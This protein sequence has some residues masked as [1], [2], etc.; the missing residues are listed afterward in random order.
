MKKYFA[1]LLITSI[2]ILTLI[3]GCQNSGQDPNQQPSEIANT[4]IVEQPSTPTP[5]P[6]ET[7]QPKNLYLVSNQ[8]TDGNLFSEVSVYL[9]QYSGQNRFIFSNVDSLNGLVTSDTDLIVW[10]ESDQTQFQAGQITNNPQ[11]IIFT[12]EIKPDFEQFVQIKLQNAQEIF[13]AGYIS[14]MIAND[15]RTGGILPNITENNTRYAEIFENGAHYLCGRC[16]P[17]YSP[18]VSFPQTSSIDSSANVLQAYAEVESSRTFVV[19]VPEQFFTE[20][21]YTNLKQN[22]RIIISNGQPNENAQ[23]FADIYVYQDYLT[24]LTQI[25]EAYPD[26]LG[27]TLSTKLTV[28]DHSEKIS[29]GKEN[30]IQETVDKLENGILSPFNVV[31]PEN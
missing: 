1:Y 29:L 17:I 15:W 11:V 27:K 5:A 7:Q 4:Q 23:Y 13:L 9:E 6:T 18:I 20:E 28:A 10:L 25:L 22:E 21:L 24:P 14:V 26:Y 12:E 8:T 30:F 3:S 16:T 2:L 31:L 19:F